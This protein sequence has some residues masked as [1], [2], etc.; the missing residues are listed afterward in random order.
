MDK[1]SGIPSRF[2]NRRV[3]Y[4]KCQMWSVRP[5]ATPGR[6]CMHAPDNAGGGPSCWRFGSYPQLPATCPPPTLSYYVRRCAKPK[7]RV[8]IALAVK[9]G[10]VAEEDSERGLAHVVEHLAF[11]ATEVGEAEGKLR[12]S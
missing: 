6:I 11:N 2:F 8:A 10:S 4:C 9:V 7:E 12:G 3:V 5:Y 1:R